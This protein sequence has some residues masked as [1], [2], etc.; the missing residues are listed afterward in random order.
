M[1]LRALGFF[2]AGALAAVV[3]VVVASSSPGAAASSSG[4]GPAPTPA[5]APAAAQEPPSTP[6]P[7]VVLPAPS[8]PPP[9]TSES[10]SSPSSPS[11]VT[12]ESKSSS[13]PS[14]SSSSSV[15]ACPADVPAD[16][17]CIP[18][19]AFL[20]GVDVERARKLGWKHLR[21]TPQSTVSVSTFLLDKT[22]VTVEAWRA[23]VATG[24]CRKGA[25]PLYEDFDAPKQPIAGIK[26]FDA[27]AFCVA[28]GKRL[29]TEAEWEKAARGTDGRMYPWGDDEA[30][31]ARAVFMNAKG[32]SC[33]VKQRS[34]K[35]ADVG[36]P[37]PVGSRPADPAGTY[38]LAG[39][40]WEWVNDWFSPSWKACGDACQGHDPQGPCAG[41][42]TCPGHTERVVR[43]GS[44]YWP[45]DEMATWF[46]RPHMPAN[47]PVFHHFGF[48]CAR[49]L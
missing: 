37:E 21:A 35:N 40:S 17:V 3:V 28:Q 13:S 20:R 38:D 31:C 22:E 14:P 43:G 19:G 27:R 6:Q 24:A 1:I 10:T 36:R 39:N 23:C 11:P 8:S 26:W 7:A 47:S 29:P 25:G 46:R 15:A 44:W 12:S 49:S 45:A 30:T 41:K 48:R 16:M 2:G 5:P 33:G 9:V 18:G 4:G 32:R 34:V 42:D